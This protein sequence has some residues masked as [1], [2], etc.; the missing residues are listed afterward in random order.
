MCAWLTAGCVRRAAA[1]RMGAQARCDDRRDEPP[2]CGWRGGRRSAVTLHRSTAQQCRADLSCTEGETSGA[3]LLSAALPPP[4][5]WTTTTEAA[6]GG[7]GCSPSAPLHPTCGRPV[8]GR[9]KGSRRGRLRTVVEEALEEQLARSHRPSVA[10]SERGS[11][12]LIAGG[13]MCGVGPPDSTWSTRSTGQHSSPVRSRHSKSTVAAQEHSQTAAQPKSC[14]AFNFEIWPRQP[15]TTPCICG[16][17][18]TNLTSCSQ[19]RAERA[20]LSESQVTADHARPRGLQRWM[21]Q[22]SQ[23][24][25]ERSTSQTPRAFAIGSCIVPPLTPLP[26]ILFT[27]VVHPC[28]SRSLQSGAQCSSTM[29]PRRPDART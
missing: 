25:S 4:Q 23:L 3:A 8:K 7:Q 24:T 11:G 19:Q 28:L 1:Q 20:W 22:H 15:S 13:A 17:D 2:P 29:S 12:Q 5:R 26:P 9:A 21:P 27:I 6:S 16:I 18:L 10:V 14:T